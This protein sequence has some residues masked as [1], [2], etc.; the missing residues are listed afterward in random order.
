MP[1]LGEALRSEFLIGPEYSQLNNG[2]YGA[3]PKRVRQ[4]QDKYVLI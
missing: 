4:Y 1:E 3:C 2:S